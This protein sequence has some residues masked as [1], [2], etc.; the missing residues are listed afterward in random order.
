MLNDKGIDL[1]GYEDEMDQQEPEFTGPDLTRY[2]DEPRSNFL[3]NRKESFNT[4]PEDQADA[5]KLSRDSG[6]PVDAVK[7]DKEAV[8]SS[9]DFTQYEPEAF[10]K[11][12]PATS[13]FISDNVNNAIISRA[14][15]K[16]GKLQSIEKSYDK[17]A[18]RVKFEGLP[19]L[20][21]A[22][23]LTRNVLKRPVN[24]AGSLVDLA[25]QA[26]NEM[27]AKFANAIMAAFT[28]GVSMSGG[29]EAGDMALGALVIGD[30]YLPRYVGKAEWDDMR[31]Q[32]TPDLIQDL[33]DFLSDA[34][35]GYEPRAVYEDVQAA[36]ARGDVLETVGA[37]LAF[38]AEQGPA[39]IVDMAA[40]LYAM[41]AYIL[42]RSSEM[43]TRRA[44]N[45]N[46]DRGELM[47]SIT[48]APFAVASAVFERALPAAV[49][50]QLSRDQVT[51]AGANMLQRAA[52]NIRRVAPVAGKGAALEGF[53][54]AVQSGIIEYIGETYGTEAAPNFSDLSF[55]EAG[56][57]A[58]QGAIV[59]A[60][61]GGTIAGA[62]ETYNI[63]AENQARTIGEQQTAAEVQQEVDL[64]A[65]DD[66]D[67]T[68]R[69]S[70][71][72]D[73]DSETF[74]Q[75]INRVDAGS[76]KDIY[77]DSEQLFEYLSTM[78]QEDIEAD[79]A[80]KDLS[81]RLNSTEEGADV[82]MPLSQFAG[83]V[84][85][86]E[87][88]AAL[89][90]HLHVNEESATLFR[91][92]ERREFNNEFIDQLLAQAE[93][94]G[95]DYA[96]AQ[97][98]MGELSASLSDTGRYTKA[99]SDVVMTTVASY[100]S[101]KAK[102]ENKSVKQVFEEIGFTIEGPQTGEAA[103]IASE[104]ALLNQGTSGVL[105]QPNDDANLAVT[106]NLS[107]ENILAAA[108]LGGLAAPSIATVRSDI[109]EFDNFGEVSL[110]A[111]PSLLE[112]DKARTFDADIYSPRQPRPVFNIN[113]A[114][115]NEMRDEVNAFSDL[116]LSEPDI[117]SMEGG[118]GPDSIQRSNAMKYL[119]LKE[120]GKE[121]KPKNKKIEPAIKKAAKLD[122]TD[123]LD[124]K[125]QKIA[126]EHYQ[127]M[128]DAVIAA[129]ASRGDKYSD[130]WFNENGTV[131][132]S[133]LYD[134]EAEVR[135]FKST[136][137]I[138]TVAMRQDL[139]KKFR[140]K[141]N[142]DDYDKWAADKFNSMVDS[143]KLFKGFTPSGNRK[144]I[145]YSMQNVVKE[146]TQQ[147][148]AGESS[149]Y[150]AG[151]VRS[152]FANE[153]KTIKQVQAKRNEI[154]SEADMQIIK[155]ESEDV[156]SQALDDLKPFYKFEADS[157]GYMEDAGT[158]IME[159]RKG[160]NE[161]FN[162]TP[163]ASKIIS[164]LVEYLVA[165][166]SSYF[167]TKIQRAVQFSEFNTAVVPAGMNKDALQ[168]LKDAGLKI[169]TYDP[170]GVGKTRQQVIAEQKKLLFQEGSEQEAR[171]YY[172]PR[173]SVIRLNEASNLTT[174]LHEFAHFMLETEIN[175]NSQIA[176]D[177]G[178]YFKRNAGAIA[179]E[180]NEYGQSDDVVLADV[181]AY[182]DNKTT[183]DQTKD[184]NVRR[185][186]H[187]WFAR[188]YEAYLMEGK[189]PSVGLRNAFRKIAMWMVEAY[190]S[191]G[192]N[193]N[194]DNEM[195]AVFDR[196]LATEEQ[197]ADARN[198]AR[199]RPLFTDATMA[200]M[201]EARFAEY[202]EENERV[203]GEQT[204]TLRDKLVKELTRNT[205][206]WW[207][208][209]S[210]DLVVE[211]L[212]EL[213][214][215]RVYLTTEALKN[216]SSTV[217]IQADLKE[218]TDAI[219]AVEKQ[220]REITKKNDTVGKFISKNGGLSRASMQAEGI[221]P[222]EFKKK[223]K[224]FGKPL[225]PKN[226]GMTV[227]DVAELLN[228]EGMELDANDT[229]DLINEMLDDD[230]TFIDP[231]V[232][233][234]VDT[235]YDD[236]TMLEEQASDIQQSIEVINIK[237]DHATVKADYGQDRVDS[238]GTKSRVIPSRLV[239]MT[240][241]GQEGAHPDDVAGLFGYDTG[242]E[243]INDLVTAPTIAEQ[244]AAMAEQQMLDRHGDILN[245]GTIAMQADE[246]VQ[247]DLRGEIMLRELKALNRG[248]RRPNFEREEIKQLAKDRIAGLTYRENSPAKY[249][250]G[251]IREAQNA[252]RFLA[253]GDKDAAANAKTQ[254]AVFHYLA[255]EATDARNQTTKAIE[256]LARY[257]K[258]KV[259]EEIQKAQNGYWEQI[260]K[261]LDRFEIKKTATL[262]SVDERNVEINAWVAERVLVDGD[263]LVLSAEIL[264]E[265][266]IKHWKD[267]PYSELQGVVASVAN[268]EHVARY[269]NK[270]RIGDEIIDY[271][272]Y[273]NQWTGHIGRN[274][275]K[276]DTKSS[277][278]IMQDAAKETLVEAG[279]RWASQLTKIP[280]LASW[281]D[282]GERAG[283]SH[284]ALMTGVNNALDQKLRLLEET[285]Q[286]VMDLL[287]SRSKEDR[288]R[289]DRD[290]YVQELGQSLKGHQ[291]LA[292]ALNVGNAGN[293]RKLLLGE[294][295]AVDDSQVNMDNTKLKAVLGNMTKTD[296]EFVQVVWD[297]M[298]TLYPLLSE[299]H[300][301][302]SGLV[303]PKV[304][305]TPVV[306]PFGTFN[307]GYYPAKY[308]PQRSH[309][310]DKNRERDDARVD[311][312]FSTEGSI[313]NSVTTSATQERTGFYDRIRLDI[314]VVPEHF[315]ETIHFITHHDAVRQLN[316]LIRD[317]AV[318]DAITAVMGEAEFKQLAP[319]LNDIAKDGREAPTKSYPDEIMGRLRFGTT[320]TTMG[321]S[322]STGLM[323]TF[324]LLTTAGE[325]GLGRTLSAV[326]LV[327]G[328][329]SVT[330]AVRRLFGSVEEMETGWEF[331]VARSKVMS[332]R[333]QTMDREI[334]NA[335][336]RLK[337]QRGLL[338]AV[339]ET[340]MKH[341]AIMQ[342]YMVDLPTWHAA[343]DKGVRDFGDEVRAAKYA[344][345]AV[346]N[347]QG[348]G[349]TKDMASLMRNQ[350][351]LMSTFTMFMTFFSAM[352]NYTR[353]MKRASNNGRDS[354]T[355]TASKAMFL[356]IVP[357]IA[358]M[359]LRG[360][361]DEPDDED[362]R[363]S[364]MLTKIALYPVASV[365]IARDVVSGL[366]TD[367][368]YNSSPVASLLERGILGSKQATESSFTDSEVTRTSIKNA[369]KLIGAGV[370]LPGIGQGWKSA[371][372][373]FE[374]IEEG[375]DFSVR[376]LLL[377]PDRK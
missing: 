31:G 195:R 14:D 258:K 295:W 352:G 197:I 106:H 325:V 283:M 289:H 66:L 307:G 58:I 28:G 232:G 360:E 369:S 49:R 351:K 99:E 262:R 16:S 54:E 144:Y 253:A 194:L 358:E 89:R 56:S 21:F 268:I 227:D 32:G 48:A 174:F 362:E 85:G 43:G 145:D 310:A 216:T 370:G 375:E 5:L 252:V 264:S 55:S 41:P 347:L 269:S 209:E 82:S 60:P 109:S 287:E 343:Y 136:G 302:T 83:F 243:M 217:A 115:F 25:S 171:G 13:D 226:G 221:D 172:D 3:A 320:L 143:K 373:I 70:D 101:S 74:M 224:V 239:G 335:M 184:A 244:A 6:M 187:E 116:G 157:W 67:Q 19:E 291:V 346:E 96:S 366:G 103:R 359:I 68:V 147:L 323:Q 165:L 15:L 120:Q 12:S 7:A 305:S 285:T 162:M 46:R 329:S 315:N 279:R 23:N 73:L 337:N 235:L 328:R 27:S 290:V 324:G 59:G 353:D 331:A 311:S 170:K 9:I 163:E 292:V 1:S 256:K 175:S 278:G 189:A 168:V 220:I 240:A 100:L 138:D 251:E 33:G 332:N 88:Y 274:A 129:D 127:K 64:G 110:L 63:V 266:Y 4:K 166:P 137:A 176:T 273:V 112:S 93:K 130:F 222:D 141:K 206:A 191:M 47:D 374:T 276:F 183:G 298:N 312:L 111:D 241:T 255:L 341:I 349:A 114:K 361:L 225:F 104:M 118:S 178:A 208:Q 153:M 215:Q 45:D 219:A 207:K 44:L 299:V 95:S 117:Q 350:T 247:N 317:P 354:V 204:E 128:L 146:M 35:M 91:Q 280:Y 177:A 185:A 309:K 87:H 218:V 259:R 65:L 2:E 40:T 231:D 190:K 142:R 76:Q 250:R 149:F 300:R 38:A 158:A 286:P 201:T 26:G 254:Q 263:A 214:K 260:V 233:G 179:K 53:T 151:T 39:S 169:K 51:A 107:A 365:P 249:R 237:L 79:P 36:A 193:V 154:V 321:F 230:V 198:R 62:A 293:L 330:R 196:L 135:R 77:I 200:G 22:E 52:Q 37:G 228:Q 167:E 90:E 318:E 72:R 186:T 124:P 17:L 229:L 334:R 203:K 98:L 296:W 61:M 24:L 301:K 97:E 42:A 372:H 123:V 18:G 202:T 345:F 81:E 340:S 134:F 188:S 156:F 314:N 306:T 336:S 344:D 164:D 275:A 92:E 356:F 316:K 139:D 277:R 159:G 303:P 245:D 8:R 102:T 248:T 108:E 181:V 34:T 313:Q 246:A 50:N 140:V 199:M 236:I 155:D 242:A 363:L 308:S 257:N 84:A 212:A 57:L 234:E 125:F 11:E 173:N 182:V 29:D 180:A 304:V 211:N 338:P 270:I 339:Q 265:G 78:K 271:K 371:D 126:T 367:F 205:K 272:K 86:T 69:T 148:Q 71:T 377:G 333:M 94:E 132:I 297:Q 288:Q 121:P 364:N 267:L 368:G 327:L 213:K 150:G 223:G 131:L 152:K 75:F 210:A 105:N 10:A 80:L 355:T 238:R 119:W 30:D 20:G 281:L 282:G 376:Q 342:T 322:A 133:K 319:W 294:G 348:S 122:S 326:G 284:D 160:L 192:L 113:R 261:I 161:A 357:V